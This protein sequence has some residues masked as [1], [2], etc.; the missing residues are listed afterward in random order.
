M[1]YRIRLTVLAEFPTS[2]GMNLGTEKL[3][4]IL[5]IVVLGYCSMHREVK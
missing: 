5:E 3:G 2:P 4:I 1:E